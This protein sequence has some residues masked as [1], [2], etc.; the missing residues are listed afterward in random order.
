MASTIASMPPEQPL[1]RAITS[2]TRQIHQLLKCISFTTKAHVQI[3][4][5]GIRF[6]ADHSRVM[7][8][9]AFLDK[10]LFTKYTLNLP[11]NDDD[12]SLP[13]FQINLAA[14]L[15]ALLI[16][17][18]TDMAAR[19]AKADAEPYRSNLR[20]YRPDAF[21]N[22]TLG[23]QGT[24]SLLYEE[25]G[26]PLSIIMEETGVKTQCNMMTYTPDRPDD[27]PFDRTDLTFK[28]I[29]Q[30]RWLLDALSELAPMSPDRITITAM[31]TAPYLGLASGGNLGSASVDFTNGRDLL[32]TF[33]VRE[34]WT[35]GFKFDLVKSASEAMRIASKVS[36]RGDGQGVLSLQ[37]MVEV[38]GSDVS[39]LDFRFVPYAESVMEDEEDAGPDEADDEFE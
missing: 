37:F 26:S 14:F 20:N 36:F 35:Q 31:P 34:K 27:I 22:Q 1:F 29:M 15:E 24:C 39:F 8:G 17:G 7:Q 19:Q 3:T 30:A 25:D 32:E 9:V 10:A 13:Q 16:F 6:S 5:E 33:S 38:E 12:T 28:I 18:A 4:Q 11:D 2:S 23:I 21:S